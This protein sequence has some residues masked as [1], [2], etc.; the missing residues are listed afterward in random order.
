MK[1]YVFYINSDGFDSIPYE[2]YFDSRQEAWQKLLEIVAEDEAK[3]REIL[4]SAYFKEASINREENK[5]EGYIKVNHYFTDGSESST[6][7]TLTCLE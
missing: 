1:K 6:E 5:A 4:A 2:G 3:E 7:Y